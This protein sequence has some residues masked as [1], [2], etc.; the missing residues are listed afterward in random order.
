MRSQEEKWRVPE[1]DPAGWTQPST[2]GSDRGSKRPSG[3]DAAP[4]DDDDGAQAGLI[5]CGQC[6]ALN[7]STNHYC[8]SCGATVLD[9]FHASEGLRVYERA[10]TA[11]RLIDIVPAGAELDIIED[12]DAPA[13]FVRV[14]LDRGRL[15]YIRFADVDSLAGAAAPTR[16]FAGAPDVNIAA[17]GCITQTS[18]LGALLLLVVLSSLIFLFVMRTNSAGSGIV[19]L[20][21]CVIVGPLLLLTIGFFIFARS[22]DERLEAEAEDYVDLTPGATET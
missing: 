8:A 9:A 17:R 4:T 6:G 5:F 21:A 7:P 11:S 1:S 12:P 3:S 19:A 2:T 10:D 18:A 15:G 16:Q 14:K 22:R 20:S 13:D